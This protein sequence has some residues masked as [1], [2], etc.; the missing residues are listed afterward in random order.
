DWFTAPRVSVRDGVVFLDGTTGRADYRD[1]AGELAQ[2][3]QGTV[4]VVNRIEVEADIRSTFGRAADEL[5]RLYRRTVQAWP[6]AALVIVIA[7]VTWLMARLIGS[8][9]RRFFAGR[10]DSPLLFNIVVRALTI[11]VFLLGLYFVL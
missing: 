8:L 1:W 11:P 4:A 6:L 10:I 7:L 2:N 9:A 5:T 3:T